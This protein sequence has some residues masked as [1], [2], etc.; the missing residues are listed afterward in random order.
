MRMSHLDGK[1]LF[2]LRKIIRAHFFPVE[3]LGEGIEEMKRIQ[4]RGK[5]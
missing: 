4:G 3:S 1:N 5:R 2:V